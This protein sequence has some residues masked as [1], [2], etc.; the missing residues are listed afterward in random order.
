MLPGTWQSSH[1]V[2]NDPSSL[3]V[4]L[5]WTHSENKNRV[6]F[7]TGDV[8]GSVRMMLGGDSYLALCAVWG[9]PAVV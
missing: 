5:T 9:T 1:W 7:V 3:Y 6:A 4:V 2:T 8:L